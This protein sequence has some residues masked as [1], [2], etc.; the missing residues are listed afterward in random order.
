MNHTYT[1]WKPKTHKII[2]GRID[3]YIKSNNDYPYKLDLTNFRSIHASTSD[4]HTDQ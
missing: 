2:T 1:D 3:P 4:Q